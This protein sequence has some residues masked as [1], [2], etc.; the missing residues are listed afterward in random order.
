[1]V[2]A[3]HRVDFRDM[4]EEDLASGLSLSRAAGWNQTLA[5]WRYLLSLGPGLFRVGVADG[6]LLA[7]GGAVRY[8]EAL[9][10]ICMIL[11]APDAR[12][13]GLGMRIF[14]EVK[15]RCED[16]MRAGRLR[17]VGLDATPAGRRIYV[18]RGFTDGPSLVRMRVESKAPA[19]RPGAV[20]SVA[21]R[22]IEGIVA[23]D[24]EVFGADRGG[25]LRWA[26]AGAP[27]LAWCAYGARLRGYCF[28][29]RGDHSDQVGPIVAEDG[30]VAMDLVRACLS[31]AR[32]RPLV[33]DARVEPSWVAALGKVGFR[34][35]RF[36]TRMYLGDARAPARP[37]LERAV[38]GPEFG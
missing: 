10:W 5:D 38:L 28:G 16:D 21:A 13:R 24:R 12:G 23:F 34:E 11:V 18:Q 2:E 26:L 15:G 32:D 17:A 19:R 27:E 35:Q 3:S 20:R 6:R 33:V 30:A 29:R 7:A 1:V 22:D 37:A 31:T 9:A 36:F 4:Q 25:V 14:D 8:G